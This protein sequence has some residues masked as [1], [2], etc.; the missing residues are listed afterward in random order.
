[1][2]GLYRHRGQHDRSPYRV[3]VAAGL[4]QVGSDIHRGRVLDVSFG[5]DS[6]VEV[7]A[8]GLMTIE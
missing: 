8:R 3:A 7:S 2:A 5:N 1:M 4:N 6:G